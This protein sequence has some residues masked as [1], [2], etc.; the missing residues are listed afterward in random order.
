VTR[1][2]AITGP[3]SISAESTRRVPALF[4]D[5]LRPFASRDSHFYLGG[6]IGIDTIALG[7]LAEHTEARLT[8]VVPCGVDDQPAAAA[9]AIRSWQRQGRTDVME[10]AA[11]KLEASAYHARNRWMVDCSGLVIAF[12]AR[13]QPSS[14]TWYTV[15]YAA[16]QGKPRLVVPI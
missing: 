1:T 3:R 16:E 2:V 13:T 6:A 10:L 5:Y 8:V 9:E 15:N 4:D 12:P 7:W 11:E 14:G